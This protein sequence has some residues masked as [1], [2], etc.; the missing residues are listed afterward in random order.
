MYCV[1]WIREEL[2]KTNVPPEDV[3]AIFVEVIQGEGGYVVPPKEFHKALYQLTRDFDILYVADEVQ[4]GMGRTGKMFASNH[5]DL[6]PDIITVAKGIASGLP[7]SATV[8]SEKIM[9][10]TPGSH[11]STF[12][13]N[14]VSCQAALTTIKLL[15]DGLIDNAAKQGTYIIHEL[16]KL[17]RTYPIIGEVRGL[18]LMLAIEIVKDKEP[19]NTHQKSEIVLSKRHFQKGFCY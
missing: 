4:S 1:V 7:L 10:W 11:A 9:N 19:K 6:V 5:F 14:P 17:E 13:G 18:G 2:F 3:A 8:A 15:E 16:Q 12:G